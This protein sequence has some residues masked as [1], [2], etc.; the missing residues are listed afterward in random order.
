[1]ENPDDK[2]LIS[3][4]T[5]GSVLNILKLLEKRGVF[6]LEDFKAVGEVYEKLFT[7]YNS[8]KLETPFEDLMLLLEETENEKDP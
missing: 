4:G 8:E 6:D 7:V 2:V 3:R 1:M 5:V